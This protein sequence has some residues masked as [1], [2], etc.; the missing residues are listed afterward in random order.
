[1]LCIVA[2]LGPSLACTL[3]MAAED[4]FI[5]A[6]EIEPSWGDIDFVKVRA[7]PMANFEVCLTL[8]H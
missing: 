1:M 5:M 7:E 6:T 3:C 4:Q 8:L 2:T